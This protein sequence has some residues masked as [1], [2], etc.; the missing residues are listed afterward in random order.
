MHSFISTSM[1]VLAVATLGACAQT[2][3]NW[4][5]RFGDAARQATALQVI[6][7]AAPSR[8][9]GALRT[10]GKAAS[11]TMRAYADSFGYAVKE[12]KPEITIT[13]ATT[14]R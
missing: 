2:A 7:P 8:Q 12:A 5:S 11:G 4:E 9:V 6:D 10:D 1:A 3:P 14:G 13:P